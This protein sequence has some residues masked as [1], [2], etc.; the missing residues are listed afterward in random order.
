MQKP[1]VYPC[2]LVYLLK[3]YSFSHCLCNVPYSFGVWSL[4]LC[5]YHVYVNFEV[6]KA[7][8]VNLK[9]PYRLLQGLF[10]CPPYGHYLSYRLHLRSE[11]WICS[12]EF[13]KSKSWKFYYNLVYCG[14]KCG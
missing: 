8:T 2:K 3:A 4:E 13:F 12:W 11:R 9:T 6:F 5:L 10:K 1:R 14:F 7:I